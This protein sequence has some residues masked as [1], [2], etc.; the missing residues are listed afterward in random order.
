MA[1]FSL[2][3]EAEGRQQFVFVATGGTSTDDARD[4]FNGVA[5]GVVVTNAAL[6]PDDQWYA[7]DR[8]G[9]MVT[10]EEGDVEYA[11][12]ILSTPLIT[13]WG[14]ESAQALI[15]DAAVSVGYRE[16]VAEIDRDESALMDR[17]AERSEALESLDEDD[18]ARI[19]AALRL[20]FKTGLHSASKVHDDDMAV[21]MRGMA[22]SYSQ[23]L[24][25]VERALDAE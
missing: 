25:K 9:I 1:L 16:V 12:P 19:A 11:E 15:D 5:S 10:Q 8:E 2:N 3:I 4:A 17:A 18:L 21:V 13:V 22:K 6:V 7:T 23:T 24:A 14:T 20:A